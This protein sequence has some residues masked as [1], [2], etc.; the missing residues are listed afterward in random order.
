M[1]PRSDPPWL[2]HLSQHYSHILPYYSL[3][4]QSWLTQILGWMWNIK[5][6]MEW[7]CNGIGCGYK[8]LPSN[9]MDVS[10]MNVYLYTTL[11]QVWWKMFEIPVDLSD[12]CWDKSCSEIAATLNLW[13]IQNSRRTLTT[14]LINK[15]YISG[16]PIKGV[17]L[18]SH[19]SSRKWCFPSPHLGTYV[20]ITLFKFVFIALAN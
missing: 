10:R 4:W 13:V 7:W 8:W 6:L 11:W 12:T 2:R 15:G 9:C 5:K 18:T 19:K 17:W 14:L 1:L 16:W 3:K 20:R